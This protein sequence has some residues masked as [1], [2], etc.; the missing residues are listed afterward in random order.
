MLPDEDQKGIKK[1]CKEEWRQGSLF[2]DEEQQKYF[3]EVEKNVQ[4]II[5]QCS[6]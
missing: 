5:E 6:K 3:I 1:R 4:A 2:K